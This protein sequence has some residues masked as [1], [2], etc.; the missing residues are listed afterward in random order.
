MNIKEGMNF[1]KML[2]Q[3]EKKVLEIIADDEQWDLFV[4]QV[5]QHGID[6]NDYK[7]D[8]KIVRERAGAS[9]IDREILQALYIDY[10]ITQICDV[11]DYNP[12][13]RRMGQR[14]FS[15][16]KRFY[17]NWRRT[18]GDMSAEQTAR[19]SGHGG[20]SYNFNE[21][22][23]GAKY[24]ELSQIVLEEH[25]DRTKAPAWLDTERNLCPHYYIDLS[26]P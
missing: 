21:P 20:A 10:S 19:N 9:E 7:N 25:K 15:P 24:H 16:R 4:R 23:L 3:A 26:E 14:R 22:E 1:E 11:C 2:E 8:Y 18:E 12:D 13:H 5:K 17:C 6:L